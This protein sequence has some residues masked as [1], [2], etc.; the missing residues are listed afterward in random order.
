M[1]VQGQI[2]VIGATET[3]G[4][5][6]FKKR[7]LVVKTDEQY[8]QTIPVEFT[9]DKTNLLDSYS[10]GD[11]VKIGINLR[12]SEWQGKYYANIQGWNINKGEREKSADSFMPD[13]QS[14][15]AMM[16]NAEQL[17]ED[18]YLFKK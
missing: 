3:I 15:N 16:D 10:V 11:I 7:L 4:A 12:G 13:R 8:P 6:G 5:K 18:D 1:E 9:Q 14:I 2:I 17:Q